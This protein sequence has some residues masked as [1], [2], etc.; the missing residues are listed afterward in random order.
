MPPAYTTEWAGALAL[1]AC[2]RH[3][4]RERQNLLVDET[5]QIPHA[6][7]STLANGLSCDFENGSLIGNTSLAT[8]LYHQCS[9]VLGTAFSL[10]IKKPQSS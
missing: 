2:A 1:R 10:G 8:F 7:V 9:T 3:E 4:A 6:E 5:L